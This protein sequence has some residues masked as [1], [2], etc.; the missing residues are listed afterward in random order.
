ME[1]Y[2]TCNLINNPLSERTWYC[3]LCDE[4]MN[5]LIE[6]AFI[7]SNFN[8][9]RERFAFTVENMKSIIPKLLR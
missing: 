1:T 7:N 4:N 2:T 6:T 9:R 5:V 3:S 8:K